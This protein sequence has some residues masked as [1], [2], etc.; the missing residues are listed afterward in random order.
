[1]K[2]LSFK[3]MEKVNGG[4]DWCVVAT[5]VTG[6]GGIGFVAG[7]SMGGIG[8]SLYAGASAYATLC[9]MGAFNEHE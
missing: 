2:T 6:F 8:L 1:M 5:G 3:Q 7:L 9:G 4:I